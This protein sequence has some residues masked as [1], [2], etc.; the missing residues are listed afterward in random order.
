M[1]ANLRTKASSERCY[2]YPRCAYWLRKL[3][4]LSYTD[5]KQVMGSLLIFSVSGNTCTMESC[6]QGRHVWGLATGQS[7][8]SIESPLSKDGCQKIRQILA[9]NLTVCFI[10]VGKR[11]HGYYLPTSTEASHNVTHSCP[12]LLMILKVK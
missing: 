11:Q 1:Y 7:P 8:S 5:W 10:K 4:R 3:T 6:G 9:S 2:E 12:R